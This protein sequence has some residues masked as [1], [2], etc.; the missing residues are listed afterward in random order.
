MTKCFCGPWSNV[1]I[2]AEDVVDGWSRSTANSIP[3]SVGT[4]QHGSRV[5]S[6][7]VPTYLSRSTSPR[8]ANKR[9]EKSLSQSWSQSWS[10]SLSQ[11]CH[12]HNFPSHHCCSSLQEINLSLRSCPFRTS[13]VRLSS[14][15]LVILVAILRH[16]FFW[17]RLFLVRLLQLPDLMPD[18]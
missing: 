15:Q 9:A 13:F 1:V 16:V 4:H 6:T 2:D 12:L 3:L 5:R 18:L 10:Q 7:Y 17:V 14:N 11:L 8:P